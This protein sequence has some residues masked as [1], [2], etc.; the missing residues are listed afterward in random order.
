LVQ[1]TLLPLIEFS[2]TLILIFPILLFSSLLCARFFALTSLLSSHPISQLS[3]AVPLP[4]P[5]PRTYSMYQLY[6]LCKFRSHA[7]P[8]SFSSL[9]LL[10][11]HPLAMFVFCA[12]YT[13]SPPHHPLDIFWLH[14]PLL[15]SCRF[16]IVVPLTGPSIDAV[17]VVALFSPFF[18]GSYFLCLTF[19]SNSSMKVRPILFF[20]YFTCL[21][22]S[23]MALYPSL[24]FFFSYSS[25]SLPPFLFHPR[26]RTS[27]V[28]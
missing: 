8:P 5:L 19:F 24:F 7:N 16:P 18:S 20:F 13:P 14:F 21:R 2:F 17:A 4:P 1:F 23:A 6:F 22:S 28:S 10:P 25:F 26:L 27:Q 11:L 12:I 15:S 9:S 3:L